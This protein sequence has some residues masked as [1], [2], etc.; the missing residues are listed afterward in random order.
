MSEATTIVDDKKIANEQK[1]KLAHEALLAHRDEAFAV[2]GDTFGYFTPIIGTTCSDPA[3]EAKLIAA[4]TSTCRNQVASIAS[5]APVNRTG[6]NNFPRAKYV[7]PN[8]KTASKRKTTVQ[9]SVPKVKS[10]GY[11][12]IVATLLTG[13]KKQ[14]SKPAVEEPVEEAEQAEPEQQTENKVSKKTAS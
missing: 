11:D 7:Y 8:D 10:K 5:S 4:F 6:L 1:R 9:T 3:F 13:S 12:P 2:I 14:P